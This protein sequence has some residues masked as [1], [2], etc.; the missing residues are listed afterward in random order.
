MAK[1]YDPY[2]ANIMIDHKTGK[3]WELPNL[4]RKSK[5]KVTKKSWEKWLRG[6]MDK[7]MI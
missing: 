2:K 1:K 6:L 7:G 5:G 4:P 3:S